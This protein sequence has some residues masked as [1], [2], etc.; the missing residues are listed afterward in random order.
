[1]KSA[2]RAARPLRLSAYISRIGSYF[3][4]A[5][6]LVALG[7]AGHVVVD[8]HAFQTHKQSK[9]EDASIKEPPAPLVEGSV[10]GEIQVPR[11]QLKAIVVQGD[12][13]LFCGARRP[14]T[15]NGFAPKLQAMLF[16]L[17]TQTLFPPAPQYSSRR[18]HHSQNIRWCFSVPCGIHRSRPGQRRRSPESNKRPHLDAHNVLPV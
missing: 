11:L 15:R 13:T 1:M 6:G 12:S 16:S 17:A 4:M 8:A 2:S 3:F 9:F 5:V 7:Y 10:V 14:H 18:R